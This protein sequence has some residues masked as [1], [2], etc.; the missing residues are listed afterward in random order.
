MGYHKKKISKGKLGEFAKIKEEF[1]ELTDAV[2]QNNPILQLCELADLVG[3]IELYSLN[4]WNIDL[5]EI[6]EMKELTRKAFED[7]SRK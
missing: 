6:I 7:G 2:E 4:K 1:E 5:N 3:A